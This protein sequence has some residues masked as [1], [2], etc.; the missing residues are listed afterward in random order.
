MSLIVKRVPISMIHASIYLHDDVL[1]KYLTS[2]L[3]R[4]YRPNCV[5]VFKKPFDLRKE[6][7]IFVVDDRA[8]PLR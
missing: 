5:S 6:I 7:V 4:P 1:H 8:V 2:T 3:K